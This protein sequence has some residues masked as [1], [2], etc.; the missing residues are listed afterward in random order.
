MRSSLRCFVSSALV[1]AASALA[2]FV[3]AVVFAASESSSTDLAASY[4]FCAASKA[5]SDSVFA[6]VALS[7]A[8]IAETYAFCAALRAS[9][10]SL[11][12]FSASADDFV[13]LDS[14][15]V[16]SALT[17][18]IVVIA[19]PATDARA[20]DEYKSCFNFMKQKPFF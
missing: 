2:L 3:V 18:D 20:I 13:G 7:K 8:I 5:L 9:V 15:V 14:D 12:S 6:S 17:I 10:A 1:L 4:A 11:S 19:G 16:S